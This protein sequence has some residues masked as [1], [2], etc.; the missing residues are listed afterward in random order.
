[1]SPTFPVV[2]TLAGRGPVQAAVPIRVSAGEFGSFLEG[3]FFGPVPRSQVPAV[4][5]TLPFGLV[6]I[7]ND[8]S[9]HWQYMW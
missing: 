1:M 4:N 7:V 8:V 9:T 3:S 6:V 2:A 5:V